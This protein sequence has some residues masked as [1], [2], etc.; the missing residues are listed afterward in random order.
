MIFACANWSGPQIKTYFGMSKNNGFCKVFLGAFL[1]DFQRL[2][3]VPNFWWSIDFLVFLGPIK[4]D[5]FRP[6]SVVYFWENS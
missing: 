6:F 1:D 5:D 3:H 2:S 4:I